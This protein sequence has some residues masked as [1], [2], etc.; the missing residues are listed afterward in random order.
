MTRPKKS[1]SRVY[2]PWWLWE[3][4]TAGFY[5][6]DV[7]SGDDPTE[8]MRAYADFLA[9]LDRF[10]AAIDRV[11]EAWRHSCQHFLTNESMNRIAW[12]GQSSACVAMGLPSRFRA[13]F[14][15][16]SQAQQDAANDLADKRLSEWVEAEW[17][18]Q[19]N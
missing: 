12:I 13:G 3:C 15:L 2:H 4:Y 17:L 16:L 18:R 14:K 8:A 5:A 6:S 11:F 19:N 7:P 10:G 9:D 1:L